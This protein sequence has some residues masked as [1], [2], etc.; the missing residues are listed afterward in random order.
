MKGN[1]YKK[2]MNSRRK[3]RAINKKSLLA[4][5][6]VSGM[7]LTSSVVVPTTL[8]W[9][10]KTA[11]A[12]LVSAEIFSNV[13]ASNDSGTSAAAPYSNPGDTNP[14]NFT[15]SG[16]NAVTLDVLNGDKVAIV[17]VPKGLTGFVQP[18]GNARVSTNITLQLGDIAA[19]QTLI[20]TLTPAVDTLV[21]TVD[22]LV[23]QN[24]ADALEIP[25][26]I[27]GL[28]NPL[29]TAASI[30]DISRVISVNLDD[31]YE[32]LDLL[33]Q[34]G[35][36]G[37]A[38][39]EVPAGLTDNERALIA[40]VDDGLFIVVNQRIQSILENLKQAQIQV[41]ILDGASNIPGIGSLIDGVN[42]LVQETVNTAK[43]TLNVTID[44]AQAV[45]NGTTDLADQIASASV[46]GQ[47]TVVMPTTVTT[48]T[49]SELIANGVTNPSNPYEARFAGTFSQ[50]NLLT[51]DLFTDEDGNNSIWLAAEPAAEQ[52]ETPTIDPVAAGDTTISG[53]AEPDSTVTV[54]IGNEQPVTA[55]ADDQGNWTAEVPEV[56]QGETV[57]V[58]A[59]A[60]GKDPSEP[61]TV[62]VAGLTVAAPTASI[63][64]NETDGYPV[65]GK[66][67]PNAAIEITNAQGDVVGSG[68]TDSDGNYR[69]VIAPDRVAPE[70]N[71]NVKAIVTAGG[72]DYSSPETAITVPIDDTAEQTTAP[73]IDPVTA[74]DT[75]IN[76]TTEPGAAVSVSVSGEEP[77]TAV[78]DD[79]GSWTVDVSE[80]TEGET[81]TVIAT[82][83][84]KAPSSPVS[85]SVSGLTVAAPTATISGNETDGYPVIGKTV[86]N[87]AIEI[88]N[89]QGV[90]VGSG[91][92]DG[93]GNYRIV[94]APDQVAPEENL[95]V[96]AIVTAGGQDYRSGATPVVVPADTQ[97]NQT[98]TPSIDPVNA[99]DQTISGTAEPNA[100]VV[101]T[102]SGEEPVTV[103]ADDQG[104]WTANVQEVS[105]GET[106]TVVATAGDKEPSTPVSVIVSGIS[107][108]APTAS[109]TGNQRDGYPVAG[110]TTANAD[111]EITNAQGEVVGSGTAD[112]DGNYRIVIAP[113]QVTPEE[114]LN[115]AAIVTAGG[116]EYR[117]ANTPVTVP[118]A[119]QT[120]IPTIDTIAA[121]DTAINGTA[122]PGASVTVA[123]D[124]EEP[125]TVVANDQGDWTANVPEVSEG[126]TVTVV[127]AA[128]GKEPSIPVS[129]TVNG[130]TVNAPTASI[131]GNTLDGYPVTGKSVADA[132]IEITNAQGE[133]VG[134]GTADGNG[135]YR[136]VI[137][138]D[139][140]S[141]EEDLNVAAVVTAGGKDY[142]SGNTP[143]IVPATVLTE[144]PTVDPV[145]AGDTVVN[146]T[147]EPGATVTVNVSGEGPVTVNANEEGNWTANVPELSEGDTVTVVATADDKDPSAPVTV[148]VSGLTV[149]TPT[150][151]ISGNET[152]GYPVVGTAVANAAIE[153]TN[154]QGEIVGSGTTDDDGN[155]RIEI[156]PDQVTPE[157]NLNVTAVVSAGGKDYRSASATVVVPADN[158]ENQTETP[159]IEL[160]TAGDTAISGTAE[161]DATVTVTVNGEDPVSVVADSQGNWTADVPEISEGDTVTVV[162]EVAGKDPSIPIS[163]TA[164]GLTVSAPT[165]TISGNETDGYPVVGK[166][167]A[168]ATIEITNAQGEV[169]GTG[170]ADGE[171]NYRIIISPDQVA[172]EESLNVTAIVTA[173]GKDYRSGATTVVVPADNRENQTATPTIDPV[174]AGDKTI[175]GT[176]EPGSTVTITVTGETPITVEA[177]DQGNWTT[178]VPE[179]SEGNT[180]TV[181]AETD[182]KDPSAPISV[183][184][185]GITVAAPTASISGNEID[186][187]PVTGKAAANTTIEIT[188]AQGDV[189]A[190]GTTDGDGN[191]RI[192]IAPDQVDPEES[193]KVTAVVTAGGK[194]YRSGATPITVP[195]AN[196][197]TTPT[198]DPVTAGD[199]TISG[200]AEPGS[201]VTI[202]NGDKDPVVV[203]ADDQGNWTADIP[204]VSEGDTIT[205][206]AETDG[207]DPSAPITVTVDGLNVAAPTASI[208]GNELAG[209]PVVGKAAANATIEITN[210]EGDVV[211]TGTTDGDGNYRIVIAPDQ[212]DPEESLNVA[213]IV[214]AGGKDYRSANTPITVPE[215]NQT[216]IPTIDPVTAGDK[217]VSGTAEPGSTVTITNGDKDPVV[218]E[219]DD[220]GNWTADIPEVSEGDTITVVAETDGKD[221]S[222]PITV[223]VDGLTVTAPT[224]S[225][226]GNE[227][228]GYPVVGKA[229]PDATVE[230]TNAQ[231]DVVGTGTTDGEGNYRIVI[232]P[233]QVAPEETLNVAAIVT[234]GGKDYRSGN[235]P[236]TVPKENQTTSPTVD[237]VTAGDDTITGTAEPGSTVTITNGDKDPVVVEADE[238]GNWT[239]EVPEVSE[240]DTIT[241]VA[242]TDGKDP[243][244]PITVT[245]DGLTVDAPTAAISGNQTDGYPVVG[246]TVANAVIEITNEQGEVVGTGTADE[247][248]NYRIVI[249]PDQV[250]PE[251]N[252]NVAAI[253]TAGGKDYRSGNTPITVPMEKTATPLIDPAIAGDETVSG[254][255]EPGSSVILTI[256]EAAPVMARILGGMNTTRAFA[257]PVELRADE[258]GNW[259]I[260][261]A[262]LSEG[263]VLTATAQTDG[264]YVSDPMSIVVSPV[265]VAA[266]TATISGNES[267]GYPV[268]GKADPNVT[269]EITNAQGE[270]V[271]T[272]T[273]D[274]E[275]N[276][277]IVVA[278][279]RVEP[280]DNLYVVASVVA[281]GKEYRSAAATVTVPVAGVG[282]GNTGGGNTDGGNTGGNN[283]GNGNNGGINIIGNGNISG[284]N[285]INSNNSGGKYLP[286]TGSESTWFAS[287]IGA[288]LVAIGGLGFFKSRKK[289]NQ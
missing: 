3:R 111:I 37:Q 127:A 42:T 196:Q 68:T 52:T 97:E 13:Q 34:L 203:E 179:V 257:A 205:V 193:L 248:G 219:A 162:A 232:A 38:D 238:E 178:D 188:N 164:N 36:F 228:D 78:A 240:G 60:D 70:E 201:T 263:D 132:A 17:G 113:D 72:Q 260:N 82:A 210:A 181:V 40:N 121:G 143:I 246:E 147:A 281:G 128:D 224:A 286:Q 218:V 245:V 80:V 156:A 84:G 235:T 61:V 83:N 14:V 59:E 50:S 266:P 44:A 19:I 270:V 43:A 39:F 135:N 149:A 259:R 274:S 233:D 142:R 12:S 47:T 57:T 253:V 202:T 151:S 27:A 144:T 289:K 175:S 227:L 49:T 237:P 66:A 51:L 69:I 161:P 45:L 250:D 284:G 46:L 214:T 215:D 130:L 282:G 166:T 150:A 174:S 267:S 73:T 18:N 200:T 148:S 33:N 9:A 77:V 65:I 176:A 104:D 53:T 85:V 63:S 157:E 169:V 180:V 22:A 133:I 136:I 145:R 103:V 1:D 242:E 279:N 102:V 137:A 244:A 81:V 125:V 184:V 48:P 171:G 256:N 280:K 76:G 197:T 139:R 146:G 118:A 95:N 222:A 198:I 211:G 226:S 89:A 165:A 35:Q 243:S 30:V 221:P 223:T 98:E 120:E 101:V 182:G 86:A 236:I 55:V 268:T 23:N 10:P 220:Q 216:G 62:S 241:V 64:G 168:D 183:T 126:E 158:R 112:G 194:D 116:Q 54:T 251:E 155:Y 195:L 271:G 159:T 177:D 261:V 20:G 92:A 96:T 285:N 134:S 74:G 58:V 115:V 110:R 6:T 91:T 255:A 67:T 28:P 167:T 75:T 94:V 129:V 32:Q 191:Y 283:I 8:L 93:E 258:A 229:A 217:T 2:I 141:P 90:V 264:K 273:T 262:E 107:V 212:V 272:G 208:S 99:G 138:P 269:I 206:V 41:S 5:L 71:L 31:I 190:T 170:T 204:E 124:G 105:E 230:I 122:E 189:V 131:S 123:V 199:E 213:A 114:N 152:D 265:T 153:I 7:L 278:A 277:R 4:N 187:Y 140:V 225:I 15:I 79:Q 275:G 239:A 231:G 117:S 207:K 154:A 186:G 234:A 25:R 100:N 288:A 119:S 106:V 163:V 254:T 11:E 209:Y 247:E 185:G 24:L 276:Y 172:P 108:S 287:I 109:I 173:G 88:T 252:L 26:T 192:V 249:A 56:S 29:Y 16:S 87:A 160:V 21:G